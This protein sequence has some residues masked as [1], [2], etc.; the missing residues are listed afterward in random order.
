M[1]ILTIIGIVI[2]A[3]TIVAGRLIPKLP[4]WLAIILYIAAVIM[5]VAGMIVSRNV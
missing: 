2:G 4:N 5:I 3:G 1:N